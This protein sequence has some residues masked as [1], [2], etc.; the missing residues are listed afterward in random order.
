MNSFRKIP[1]ALV[2]LALVLALLPGPALAVEGDDV[3]DTAPDTSASEGA[4]DAP[5]S[6]DPQDSTPNTPASDD[7]ATASGAGVTVNVE[8][9]DTLAVN[10]VS[11]GDEDAPDGLQG[12]AATPALADT[13]RSLFGV[14]T[15]RTQMVTTYY[16]GQVIATE[17]QLV[18]GLAG[19]D[20]EWLAGVGI[21]ALITFCLFRLLGGVLRYG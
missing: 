1:R 12:D 10:T 21:F 9:H 5:A 17:E 4:P 14:Y 3:A 2:V 16:D 13:I 7:A 19:L 18:P 6:D 20:Y 15:P 8:Q 11:A